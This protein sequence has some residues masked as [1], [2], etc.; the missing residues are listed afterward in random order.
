MMCLDSPPGVVALYAPAHFAVWDQCQVQSFVV[1]Y[2]KYLFS[3]VALGSV[4][5]HPYMSLSKKKKIGYKI[6]NHY[7][8]L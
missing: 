4:S 5:L 2:E 3:G 6:S 7:N 8:F 1:F